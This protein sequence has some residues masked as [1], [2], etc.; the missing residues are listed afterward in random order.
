MSTPPPPSRGQSRLTLSARLPAVPEIAHSDSGVHSLDSLSSDSNHVQK[1][2]SYADQQKASEDAAA[3][4]DEALRVADHSAEEAKEFLNTAEAE[5]SRLE[6]QSG[7]KYQ[8]FSAEAKDSYNKWKGEA[9]K[10]WKK[11]RKE[12]GAEGKKAKEQAK[13]AGAW[14]EENKDNPVV[15]GNVVVLT[16][17]AAGLGAGAY[18]LNQQGQFT[19][20]VAGLGAGILGAFAVADYYV[21]Q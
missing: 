20:K 9:S 2:P 14:A 12:A 11:A 3:A 13:K 8:E 19:W 16:A 17:L 10:E 6:A 1:I 7:K 18:R 15:I 21:S 5:L 4:R